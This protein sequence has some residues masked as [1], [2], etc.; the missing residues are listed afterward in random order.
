[1]DEDSL[2][3]EIVKFE[4]KLA[5]TDFAVVEQNKRRLNRQ[6]NDVHADINSKVSE[7]MFLPFNIAVFGYY[8]YL[9]SPHQPCSIK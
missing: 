4:A 8:C 1:M 5:N 3:S 9:I 6:I 2:Q 7:F